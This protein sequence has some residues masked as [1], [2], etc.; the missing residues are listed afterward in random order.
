MEMM[1]GSSRRS[2]LQSM[3]GVAAAGYAMFHDDMIDRVL[4]ADE[5]AGGRAPSE[6]ADQEDF[7]FD[8]QRAFVIDRNVINLNNGGVS[9]SPRVVQ[10]AL[11]VF[12]DQSN[13]TP[14]QTMWHVLEPRVE[15]IRRRLAYHFGC[16]PEELAIT[17]NASEALETAIFGIDL[18]EG[19]EI[20]TTNQDY[21]RMLSSLRQRAEREGIK[22]KAVSFSV[23]PP[24][25]NELVDLFARNITTET[26]VILC[27]HITNLTGHIFPVKEICKLAA[28]NGIQTI[29]DGAHAFAHFAYN[30]GDIGCD[31][32]GTSLHKWLTAPHGTG[33]LFV[34]KSR[35]P[36]LWPL[37]GAEKPTSD[38]IRKFE[39][40][41]THPVAIKLS[42]GEALS[43]HEGIGIER[44]EARLRY[45]RNRF[46]ER[47]T[48]SPRVRC[49]TSLDPEQSC[50]IGTLSID[51]V[52][53][54]PMVSQL[55]K[56][57]R[58]LVTPIG[59]PEYS[60]I[61]VTP[62]VYTTVSE[63]DRFC[64]AVE[65]TLRTGV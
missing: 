6:L 40:I 13:Q 44:K 25:Q 41:G 38:N 56:N 3:A 2:F 50:G 64:A 45:L 62:N 1:G 10:E 31:Y 4:A 47:L 59:H 36:F 7:W 27:C 22:I 12:L 18:K 42:I 20:L 65:E 39:E 57:Y 53:P 55:W 26:K 43:F 5:A 14:A 60:G 32:Y 51:G 29:I 33:F 37:M 24:G 61:R 9:P 21:P 16:D 19:D 54:G 58:I 11:R 52:E 48:E 35:I 23:P 30:G 15:T 63:V 17:R 49:L 8:I 34:K 28:E 46:V